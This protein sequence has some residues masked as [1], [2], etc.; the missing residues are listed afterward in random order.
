MAM[1]ESAVRRCHA[2]GEQDGPLL[3][4]AQVELVSMFE[5]QGYISEGLRMHEA[6]SRTL[7]CGPT[8]PISESQSRALEAAKTKVGFDSMRQRL[9][10]HAAAAYAIY[11]TKPDDFDDG[12]LGFSCSKGDAGGLSLL[13]RRGVGGAENPKDKLKESTHAHTLGKQHAKNAAH[14]QQH[15][16]RAYLLLGVDTYRASVTQKLRM[17][18]SD[19]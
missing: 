13:V 9:C 16:T 18:Y 7:Q 8:D 12:W 2:R 10:A 6:V 1:L 5:A 4:A 15:S 19:S 3:A 11:L 17:I 14:R